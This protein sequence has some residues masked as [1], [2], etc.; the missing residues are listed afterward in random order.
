VNS[1]TERRK[2][3]QPDPVVVLKIGRSYYRRIPPRQIK[4]LGLKSNSTLETQTEHS[5]RY[6]QYLSAWNRDEQDTDHDNPDTQTFEVLE[7][8]GSL[9]RKLTQD[10][11]NHLDANEGTT[12]KTQLE[13]SDEHGR[14]ITE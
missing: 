10:E 3:K 2:D 7:N 8:G 13:Y 5:D 4:H 11:L 9:Y 14:Y 1:V 6:G 12:L